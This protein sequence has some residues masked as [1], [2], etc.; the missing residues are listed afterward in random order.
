M[1]VAPRFPSDLGYHGLR[2][3]ADEYL[4]LGETPERYEL[5]EGTVVMSPS[6]KPNHQELLVEILG[7]LRNWDRS[8]RAHRFFPDTDVRLDSG[9][10][11]RP[12]VS[13]YLRTRLP[14]LPDRLATPPDLVIEILSPASKV[15]DLITKRDDYE[16]FGVLEYWVVDPA[17]L[18]VR[19]WSREQPHL[20][21]RA[22]SGDSVP[23]SA[24]VG[25]AL[26][27]A[28]LRRALA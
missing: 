27:I 25:F 12:D 18:R 2:M 17:D 11:Y 3:T 9:L 5:I 26:N 19:A 10:V 13:V 16:R 6:P 21:E 22:V 14:E 24:L 28:E 15:I 1:S 20:V 4:A 7:Q 23:S 8:N